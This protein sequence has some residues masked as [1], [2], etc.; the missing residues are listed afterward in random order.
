MEVNNQNQGTWSALIPVIETMVRS[1]IGLDDVRE[2]FLRA[3]VRAAMKL[4]NENVTAAS[5]MLKV[6]R[7]T[8]YRYVDR[9]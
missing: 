8:V 9:K 2:R 7:N 4:A 1:N 5:R 3:Y 6:H